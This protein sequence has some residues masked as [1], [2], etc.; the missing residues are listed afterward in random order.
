[1]AVGMVECGGHIAGDGEGPVHRELALPLQRLPQRLAPDVGQ[2]VPQQAVVLAGVYQ[3]EDVR[4][5]ELGCQPDLG[6]EAFPAEDRGQLGA[7]QL[8]S[9]LAVVP[10]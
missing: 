9:N 8:Q 2:D 10:E 1:M 3:G 7:E 6:Q 4:M 5:I